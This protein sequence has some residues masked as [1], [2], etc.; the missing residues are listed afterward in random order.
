M[1]GLGIFV[2]IIALSI[3]LTAVIG[4]SI[5]QPLLMHRGPGGEDPRVRMLE[6]RVAALEENLES[7]ERSM[8]RIAEVADFN[9]QLAAPAPARPPVTTIAPQ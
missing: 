2:P 1:H 8:A 9:R 6:N 7:M 5:I 3:P 4:K